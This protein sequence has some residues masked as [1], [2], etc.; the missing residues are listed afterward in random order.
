MRQFWN[1]SLACAFVLGAVGAQQHVGVT[2]VSWSNHTGSGS[3]TLNARLHYPALL[4]GVDTRIIPAPSSA[5]FPVVVF[6]HGYGL[7]GSDY[8]EIGDAL[9]RDGYIAVMLNTAQWSHTELEADARA[10][11]E[12]MS[13]MTADPVSIYWNTFDMGRVGLLGHSMGGA[14]ISYVLNADP[15][16]AQVNPGYRCGLALAPVDP[17]LAGNGA[18]I[19]V[20]LGLV[21]GQGDTLTPP[22]N[23]AWPYYHAVTP[24]E[25]LKF[26]YEM[27]LACDHM[28]ICGLTPNSPAVF[29]RAQ[30]IACGFFGQFL[31][32]TLTGLE[33]VLGVDGQ[34]DPNLANLEVDTSVPQAWVDTPLKIGQVSRVSVTI[35]GGW[36]GL[37]GAASTALQPT[38]TTVGTLLLEESTTFTLQ[39]GPVAGER[40]D[41]IIAVPNIM[42]LV[43]TTFAVQGGGPTVTTPFTLGSALGFEIG[44]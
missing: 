35:E 10:V 42:A 19:E 33:T 14:V 7:V 9:A 38:A 26:H 40:M 24:I 2:D 25:G 12:V 27:G 4:P 6:L 8:A 16:L 3:A 41:V 5:G 37:L 23:H 22:A 32:G 36:G 18:V 29:A 44:L 17:L 39:Q 28:N 43:G 30:Q 15:A 31:G 11:H 1:L 20:P 21:S 13:L 34:S